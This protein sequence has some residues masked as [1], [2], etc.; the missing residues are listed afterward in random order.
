MI[1]QLANKNSDVRKTAA[2]ALA[3]LGESRWRQLVSGKDD[4]FS[5][6]A[7]SK[8]ARALLSLKNAMD[9]GSVEAAKALANI[10]DQQAIDKLI[11]FLSSRDYDERFTAVETLNVFTKQIPH[12]FAV[13]GSTS[14]ILMERPHEDHAP[15]DIYY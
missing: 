12:Y 14:L 10:G 8:D 2:D 11:Y 6:L 1:N 9:K 7:Q 5:H 4:D 15:V 13:N 3:A